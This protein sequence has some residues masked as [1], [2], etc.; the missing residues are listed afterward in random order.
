ML[1]RLLIFLKSFIHGLRSKKIDNP[2]T[3]RFKHS[4]LTFSL[5]PNLFSFDQL[6][7]IST[8]IISCNHSS[9]KCTHKLPCFLHCNLIINDHSPSSQCLIITLHHTPPSSTSHP[10]PKVSQN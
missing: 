3:N 6:H 4:D 5:P 9:L 7:Q 8:N 10:S 2:R 1:L